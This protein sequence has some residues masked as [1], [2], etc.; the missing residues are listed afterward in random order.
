MYILRSLGDGKFYVG[1]TSNLEDRLKRH[2]EGRSKYTSKH[3]PI[4]LVYTEVFKTRKEALARERTIKQY[5]SRD[6]IEKLI[7]K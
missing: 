5:K 1:M 3:L 2:I 6:Y 4:E 7:S